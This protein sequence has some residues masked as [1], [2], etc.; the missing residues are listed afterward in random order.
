MHREEAAE[1]RTIH[2]DGNPSLVADGEECI[3]YGYSG[4][5]CETYDW[6]TGGY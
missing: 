5:E 2:S 3:L 6:Q 4:Q 1:V